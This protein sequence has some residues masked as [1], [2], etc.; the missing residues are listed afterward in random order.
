MIRVKSTYS[1]LMRSA[2]LLPKEEGTDFYRR[3]KD[4]RRAANWKSAREKDL[5]KQRFEN[6]RVREEQQ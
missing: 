5:T 4:F 6:I 3:A 2:G 1:H